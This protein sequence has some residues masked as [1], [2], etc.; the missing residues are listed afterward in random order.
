MMKGLPNMTIKADSEETVRNGFNSLSQINSS[1]KMYEIDTA[2]SNLSL[3]IIWYKVIV[4]ITAKIP[5]N[6][7]HS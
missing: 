7:I 6:E 5:T 4:I 2:N 1:S 3:G